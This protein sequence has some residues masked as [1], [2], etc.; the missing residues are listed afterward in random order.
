MVNS[1]SLMLYYRQIFNNGLS[2]KAHGT[3]SEKCTQP[4][5]AVPFQCRCKALGMCRHS[6]PSSCQGRG[7]LPT[8]SNCWRRLATPL[9]GPAAHACAR[10]DVS[11]RHGRLQRSSRPFSLLHRPLQWLRCDNLRLPPSR[12]AP[13]CNRVAAPACTQRR[14]L[15][16]TGVR[17]LRGGCGADGERLRG[18]W[19]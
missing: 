15:G 3:M 11:I 18:R 2:C 10:C 7:R 9:K 1:S 14:H 12:V 8:L 13:P 4:S 19:W 17:V 16:L 5:K 6:L